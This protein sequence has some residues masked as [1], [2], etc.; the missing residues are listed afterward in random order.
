[1][2]KLRFALLDI[3]GRNKEMEIMEELL[4]RTKSPLEKRRRELLLI[5][6][7]SGVGKTALA[8]TMGASVVRGGGVFVVGKFDA[9][10]SDE[11]YSAI[12][13][14]CSELCGQIRE[15]NMHPRETMEDFIARLGEDLPALLEIV[16][17][18]GP[19]VARPHESMVADEST[20]S[21]MLQEAKN[22]FNYLLRRFFRV[23]GSLF[24]PLVIV[25]DDLQ[26][27]DFAS[28]DLLEVLLSDPANKNLV[29]VGCYRSN[30]ITPTH[31]LSKLIRDIKLRGA[32]SATVV[33][34]IE[35]G[36]LKE[37]DTKDML[38]DLLSTDEA[39]AASLAKICHRKTYGN[40]FF[41]IQY[42][43]MIYNMSLLE[44]NLGLTS[45]K[46]DEERIQNETKATENVVD[47][48][49]Q[50]ILQFPKSTTQLLQ[51]AACLGYSFRKETLEKVWEIGGGPFQ[52]D[53]SFEESMKLA[54]EEGIIEI[55]DGPPAVCQW[56]HDKILEAALALCTPGEL[57]ALQYKLGEILIYNL[58]VERDNVFNAVNLLNAGSPSSL[59]DSKKIELA[60]LNLRAA[61]TSVK[62]SAYES[63]SR[64]A[65][66]GI[67]L[68]P[69]NPWKDHFDL[70][71]Q[72][73]SLG[74][75]VEGCLGRV[76]RME[77]HCDLVMQQNCP[78]I[79]KVRVYHVLLD[80]TA[81]RGELPE[82]IEL[83]LQVLKQLGC[84][85][86][87]SSFLINAMTI[88]GVIGFMS[89]AESRTP[90]EIATLSPM[91]DRRRIEVMR[92]LDKLGTY[93]Y[94]S[95]N[96]LFAITILRRLKYT[97]RYGVCDS[98]AINFGG[99]GMILTGKL[100]DFQAGS[101]YARYS[102]LLLEKLESSTVHA[103]TLFLAYGFVLPWTQATR[104][105]LK[106]L[107]K[108]YEVGMQTGDTE[109]AMY[110]I[111]SYI[112]T[113]FQSGRPLNNIE[114]DCHV[115]LRQMEDLKRQKAANHVKTVLQTIQNIMGK[116]EDPCALVGS[117]MDE[118]T[119][120]ETA[121]GAKDKVTIS[122]I[123]AFRTQLYALFGRWEE[124]AKYAISVGD[125]LADQIPCSTMVA[126][127]PF[128]RGLSLFAMAR[129]S[130]QAKYRRHAKKT[131]K[132]IRSFVKKGNP[133]VRH[134]ES[135]L[136]AELA[137]L[138]GK[139]HVAMKHYEVAV[140]MAT[141][142]GFT[143][144]AALANERFAEFLYEDVK[145][146]EMAAFRVNQAVRL[147]YEW[148]SLK[149]AEML[150]EKYE[151]LLFEHPDARVDEY[152]KPSLE[153]STRCLLNLERNDIVLPEE[154]QLSM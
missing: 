93:C 90:E 102:L 116:S 24:R 149:K 73:H 98:S 138:E 103:R 11:P 118:T 19:L 53:N 127:D 7:N 140:V 63:A 8:K 35:I 66:R 106:Y 146:P 67:D 143:Q 10:N 82:A 25:L 13:S 76:S 77:Y 97:I 61:K 109:T 40:A 110:A 86:P 132:T 1:V 30:E 150:E 134:L 121:S 124:G 9:N 69:P 111:M 21:P 87:K 135:F 126:V 68:L 6:G 72:L 4:G 95:E 129:Q 17:G 45:W 131:H 120:L 50:K 108:A 94:L 62:V 125:R 23:V 12:L 133:N 58:G 139:T 54:V 145:D 51:V 78:L 152:K 101:T 60:I 137:A 59:E 81:D 141:R 136:D 142:G 31:M 144:D 64:Y 16:P 148:G 119:M 153:S 100:F 26:R 18:L 49:K 48:M 39:G 46:W 122:M 154:V 55:S 28:V 20:A 44:Y 47:L 27:A 33:T 52:G 42:L 38:L 36:N 65:S 96:I 80:S 74:A 107:L 75:E 113:S 37:N 15:K 115:Y 85:F 79:D 91:K 14:A 104:G 84:S 114:A 151:E 89:K 83:C 112:Y 57:A 2:N 5:S 41:L 34:E 92:F 32:N 29:V 117:V 128:F 22:R 70:S 147:Y 105:N 130:K 88:I 123:Q 56:V 99:L 3:Y 43:N 71:L